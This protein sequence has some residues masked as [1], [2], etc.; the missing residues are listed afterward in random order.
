VKTRAEMLAHAEEWIAAWNRRDLAAVLA[1]FAPQATFRSPRARTITGSAF[2]EGKDAI[3]DYWERSLA[4]LHQLKFTL[5]DTICDEPGQRMV[6]LYDA[7]L[8]GRPRR[9]CEFFTFDCD[10]KIS[11]E[12]LYG[13]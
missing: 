11:A 12:A 8:N 5:I 2:L 4:Q 10:H 6:V 9:A 13:D 1:A 7:E 3:R